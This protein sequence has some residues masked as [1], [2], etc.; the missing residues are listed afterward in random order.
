MADSNGESRPYPSITSHYATRYG[1]A[2]IENTLKNENKLLT[3]STCILAFIVADFKS[4]ISK[5]L[6]N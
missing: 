4:I 2:G 5:Q 1:L 6:F 3:V